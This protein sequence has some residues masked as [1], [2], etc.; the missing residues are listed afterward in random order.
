MRNLKLLTAIA[1]LAAAAPGLAV[2]SFPLDT[3]NEVMVNAI[4]LPSSEPGTVIVQACTSCPTYRFELND[5]SELKVG[6]SV[7]SLAQMRLAFAADRA[8][9]GLVTLNDDRRSI[10]QIWVPALPVRQ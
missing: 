9:L 1:L 2:E 5:R 3:V 4:E 6:D 10:K 8:A 7:V